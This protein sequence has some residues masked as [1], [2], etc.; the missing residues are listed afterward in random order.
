V[1]RKRTRGNSDKAFISESLIQAGVVCAMRRASP[2][3]EKD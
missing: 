2:Y 3:P 1:D